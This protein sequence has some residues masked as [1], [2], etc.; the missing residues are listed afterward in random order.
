MSKAFDPVPHN[1]LKHKIKNIGV[2]SQLVNEITAYLEER[3]QF[4]KIKNTASNILPVT[5]GPGLIF[6]ICK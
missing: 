4:V 6:N 3:T 1:S 5:S 2:S